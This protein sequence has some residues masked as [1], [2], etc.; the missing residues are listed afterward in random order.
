[1][2]STGQSVREIKCSSGVLPDDILDFKEPVVL[3][4]LVG[5]WPVVSA[6]LESQEA[7]DRYIRGHYVD[8]SVGVSTGPPEIEGRIFY[9]E[10]MS[11]FNFE[12]KRAQFDSVLDRLQEFQK[13]DFPPT[14]YVGSTSVDACL[15]GFR[16]KNDLDLLGAGIDTPLVSLWLGNRATIAA[17]YDIP[18][19]IA[20]VVAGKRRFTFFPPEQLENLYVGPLDFA[21]AGQAISMV[22]FRSPDFEKYPKFIEALKNSRLCE[23]GPGDAVFIPS[24]WWHHVEGLHEFNMLI[25]YWWRE[26]P[27]YLGSPMAALHHAFL[28]IRDLPDEQREAW[29]TAFNHYIFD[30]NEDVAV[31]I[32]E[33]RRSFLS[34]L[35]DSTARRLRA[36][37]LRQLNR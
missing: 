30:G 22:D 12:Q 8:A 20:C 15:P 35:D 5:S 9:N 11:G 24:M 27:A 18:D 33:L 31:H 4:G 29:R 25:N 17:H 34:P 14:I 28:S 26:A 16:E 2:V 10:D 3:K 21:P 36:L 6:C 1:M 13:M 7:A 37:L 23:L 19:N 32:P